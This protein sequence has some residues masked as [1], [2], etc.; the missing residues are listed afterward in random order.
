M[1][2]SL[3]PF[4]LPPQLE[5]DRKPQHLIDV[6]LSLSPGLLSLLYRSLFI[7]DVSDSSPADAYGG[8]A[9]L[10]LCVQC[11]LWCEQ[12]SQGMTYSNPLRPYRDIDSF[13]LPDWRPVTFHREQ[14]YKDRELSDILWHTGGEISKGQ[15]GT[16]WVE[17][18]RAGFCPSVLSAFKYCEKQVKRS[19]IWIIS[20]AYAQLSLHW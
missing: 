10:W 17:T 11:T 1:W 5:F 12:Y 20:R 6:S 14:N 2:T 13:F 7:F 19:I 4:S 8:G 3:P 18:V 9:C 16:C 15:E